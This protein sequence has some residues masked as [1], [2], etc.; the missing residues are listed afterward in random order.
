VLRVIVSG[1]VCALAC[2]FFF[3]GSLA[4]NA[5]AGA[6]AEISSATVNETGSRGSF[7]AVAVDPPDEENGIVFSTPDEGWTLQAT[8]RPARH[9][10]KCTPG[11]YTDGADIFAGD[12]NVQ[13]IWRSETLTQ[14]RVDI[15]TSFPMPSFEW[16][17]EGIPPRLCL[18]ETGASTRPNAEC[19]KILAPQYC[20]K[21][22]HAT[23]KPIASAPFESRSEPGQS[24]G[25][26]PK[27]CAKARMA[28]NRAQRRLWKAQS[29]L[30]TARDA[31]TR[32]RQ[33]HFVKTYRAA[34]RRAV[35]RT[36]R[37]CK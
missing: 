5:S 1:V 36:V 14:E 11:S 17:N 25:P 2:I 7:S 21:E 27:G 13:V 8:V 3:L 34:L 28:S 15:S 35:R 6:T 30:R 16:P 9:E 20:A 24:V 26:S 12:R 29:R 37:G 22:F 23:F 4:A 33:R 31:A 32:K 10:Y 19:A 18:E